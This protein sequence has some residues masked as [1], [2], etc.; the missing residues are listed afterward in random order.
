M[1]SEPRRA[2]LPG[3]GRGATVNWSSSNPSVATVS[4]GG[5]VTAVGHGSAIIT[6]TD[7]TVS[8]RTGTASFNMP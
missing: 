4:S 8:G 1:S 7:A 6:A 2:L 5:L 3:C